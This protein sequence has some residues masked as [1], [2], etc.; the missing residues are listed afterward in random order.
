LKFFKW[1]GQECTAVPPWQRLSVEEAFMKYADWS[2]LRQFDEECFYFDL[3]DKVDRHLGV[4]KPTFLYHYP[5]PLAMLARVRLE[6]P[7]VARR[8]EL[9]IAGV[10]LANAFEELTDA[11]EQRRRFLNDLQRRRELG[12]PTYPVDERLLQ[13]LERM[14]FCSGVALGVDRLIMLL[15]GATDIAQ[16][17]AFPDEEV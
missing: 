7:P 4:G 3:V 12:K 17:L 14:P 9:Y 13:S 6:E 1:G 11:E 15:S 10:E 2:P 16:V 5:A 8:F